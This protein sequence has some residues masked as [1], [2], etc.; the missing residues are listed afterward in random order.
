MFY[1][2]I[3]KYIRLW[4]GSSKSHISLRETSPKSL[5]PTNPK[6]ITTHISFTARWTTRTPLTI[7]TPVTTHTRCTTHT[8]FTGHF[9]SCMTTTT[10][11][12]TSYSGQ[13]RPHPANRHPFLP[14][15]ALSRKLP[16][17]PT[18]GCPILPIALS[19]EPPPF[20]ANRHPILP[21]VA[22]S[23]QQPNICI[24]I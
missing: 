5:R 21:A 23:Y 24:K 11:Q 12:P 16:P 10:T 1:L 18:D 19:H 14:I 4:A 13:P 9:W 2:R 7:H 8:R 22:R 20:P 6:S 15:A 3:L 17:F